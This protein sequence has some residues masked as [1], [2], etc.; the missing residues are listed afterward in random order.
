[1]SAQR[2][3]PWRSK[4]PLVAF[5]HAVEGIGHT[6]RTQRNMRVHLFSVVAILLA[7]LLLR[8]PRVE[9]AVLVVTAA[10]VVIAEMFNTAIEA[11]VDMITDRYHPAAKYAKDVVAGAVLISAVN[12]AVVGSIVFLSYFQSYVVKARMQSPP[13]ITVVVS[14]LLLLLVIVLLGKILGKKG[15]LA[16]GGAISGHAAVAFFLAMTIAIV[17]HSWAIALIALIL[18]ALVAQS[19]VEGKIHTLQE[20]INGAVIAM[21]L[22]IIVFKLPGVLA[23]LLP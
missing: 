19:R 6:F 1:M 9:M 17:A 12:A 7:G 3:S 23:G 13:T 4:N 22:S 21:A 18:A 16:K 11:V 2:S 5:R 8:L 20:V 10:M 14:A 15:T